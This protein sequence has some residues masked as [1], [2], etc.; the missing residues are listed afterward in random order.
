MANE[1]I[2]SKALKQKGWEHKLTQYSKSFEYVEHIKTKK[3]AKISVIIVAW[4]YIDDTILENLKLL[5]AQIANESE[6]IFVNNGSNDSHF[7]TCKEFV[8]IYV[9][10]N[11]N[12]GLCVSRNIGCL[13][14]NAPIL[15]FIDDDCIPDDN[16]LTSH[17]SLHQKYDII[18]VRGKVIPKTQGSPKPLHYDLGNQPL[19]RFNDCEGNSSYNAKVFFELQG[20]D[21][22]LFLGGE[23]SDFSIR[24]FTQYPEYRFQIYA[25]QPL[26]YHDYVKDPHRAARKKELNNIA[27]ERLRSKYPKLDEYK[28]SF[29]EHKNDEILE[30]QPVN[31]DSTTPLISVCMPTYNCGKYI[32]EAIDSVLKQSFTSYEIVILDDG[33]TDNTQAVI[34][35]IQQTAPVSIR[36]YKQ[37]NVGIPKTRNRLIE[38]AKA[39]YILWF[40]SDDLLYS[41]IMQIHAQFIARYPDVGVFYG[42]VTFFGKRQ[43]EWIV[44]DYYKRSDVL[45]SQIID[46]GS[47]LVNCGSVIKKSVYSEHGGYD[48]SY[49]RAQD[50][51]FWARIAGD[52]EVKYIGTHSIYYRFHGNNISVITTDNKTHRSYEAQNITYLLNKYPLQQLFPQLDWTRDKS[53][54]VLAYLEIAKNYASRYAE[55]KALSYYQKAFAQMGIPEDNLTF[56]QIINYLNRIFENSSIAGNHTIIINE[57]LQHKDSILNN[58]LPPSTHKDLKVALGTLNKALKDK[59]WEHK[60]GL[61]SKYFEYAERLDIKQEPKISIIVIAWK[62]NDMIFRN[63]QLLRHQKQGETELIFLNNGCSDPQ[64]DA[65]KEYVDTYI[66]LNTNTGSPIARNIAT[67]FAHAPILCFVDDDC[68]PD[69]NLIAAHT[70]IHQTY[71]ILVLRGRVLPITPGSEKPYHYELDNRMMPIFCD[72]EGNSSFR[73]STFYEVNGWNDELFI[74]NEGLDLCYR[75]FQ[76]YPEYRYQIFHPDPLIYHDYTKDETKTEERRKLIEKNRQTLRTKYPDI[77]NFIQN[78]ND[79]KDDEIIKLN[80]ISNKGISELPTGTT[81]DSNILL[82]KTLRDKGWDY[83]YQLYS[84]HFGII[85]HPQPL[86]TPKISIIFVVWK[87]N[88][89]IENNLS[90]L[91]QQL[92]NET[93]IILVNNGSND[94]K[95]ET[96]KQYANIYIKLNNNTGAYLSRNIGGLFANAPILFFIEDDCIPDQSLIASHVEL[97][98][99]YDIISARGKVIPI[100]EG[101]ENPYH[102]DL[103]PQARCAIGNFEGNVTYNA[104]VFYSLGGWDDEI[105]FGY[106][107]LEFSLRIWDKYPE[108]RYQIYS[109]QPL[110]YHDFVKETQRATDKHKQQRSS[111]IRLRKKYPY[112]DE[113]K[114]QF[115]LHQHDPLVEKCPTT[116]QATIPQIPVLLKALREKGWSHKYDLYSRCFQ[117]IEYILPINAPKISLVIVLWKYEDIIENNLKSIRTQMPDQTEIVLVNNGSNDQRLLPLKQYANTFVNLNTNTGSYL[118]RNIG[119]L[120]ANAPILFFYEDDCIPSENLVAEHIALHTRYDIIAARGKVIP[121]TEGSQEPQHYNLGPNLVCALGNCEG[122]ITF[123]AQ[124]FYDLSG[125]DDDIFFG[126]G[127]LELSYRILLK[128][129]EYRY[130]IYAPK[131]IIHHD[132]VKD[133]QRNTRKFEMQEDSLKRL[134][135]KYPNIEKLYDGFAKHRNDTIVECEITANRGNELNAIINNNDSSTATP[136]LFSICIPTYNNAKY[137]QA[138][139]ESVLAQP[140]QDYEIIILDDGSTDNTAEVIQNIQTSTPDKIRY[141]QQENQGIP[142][143]RNNLIDL[144]TSNWILWLDS[145][146][147][148]FGDV[149]KVYAEFMGKYKDA[150]VFYGSLVYFGLKQGELQAADYYQNSSSLIANSV[151]GQTKVPGPGS[152]VKKSVYKNYGRYNEEFQRAEDIE[153]VSRIAGSVPCKY[154]HTS[155]VYCRFHNGNASTIKTTAK[156]HYSYNA[157]IITYLLNKYS[158]QE[159]FRNYNWSQEQTTKTLVYLEIARHYARLYQSDESLSYYQKAFTEAGLSVNDLS[160]QK[161][162]DSLLVIF[163]KKNRAKDHVNA[164]NELLKNKDKIPEIVTTSSHRFK[165]TRTD[166]IIFTLLKKKKWTSRFDLYNQYFELAEQWDVKINPKISVVIVANNYSEL[167]ENNLLSLKTQLP[168]QTEIILLNNGCDDTCFCNLKEKV[169][170]YIK[171]TE[172]IS[173]YIAKNIAA[174]FTNARL[175]LFLD[176]DCIP[177]ENLVETHLSAHNQYDVIAVRGKIAPLTNNTQL[178]PHCD[179]GNKT[180]TAPCNMGNNIFIISAV[181]FYIGGWEDELLH[182]YGGEEMSYKLLQRYSNHHFQ[183]YHP[184]AIISVNAD[185]INAVPTQSETDLTYLKEKYP[186]FH[187]VTQSWS[188]HYEDEIQPR[189]DDSLPLVKVEPPK[190]NTSQQLPMLLKTLR[191]RGWEY[192]YPLYSKPFHSVEQ[193]NPIKDPTISVVMVVWKFDEIILENFKRLRPQRQEETEIIL[194]NNGSDDQRVID[195]QKYANIYVKLNTNTGAYLSRN[196]GSVFANAPTIL[197]LE[198]DCLPEDNLIT[199]FINIHNKYDVIVARGRVQ[200]IT[201]DSIIPAQYDFGFETI[202]IYGDFEGNVTYNA[203]IFYQLGGW[204]DE[205]FMGGGGIEIAYRIFE[206]YPEY[207]YQIYSP[208]P[209]VYHD[210]VKD[211]QRTATKKQLQE[212][213]HQRLSAK[214]PKLD[215]FRNNYRNHRYDQIFE[216][217]T[218]ILSSDKTKPPLVSICIPTFNRADFLKEAIQSAININFTDYEIVIVDDGSTDNTRDGVRAFQAQH[219]GLIRYFFKK[220]EG[221]PKTRNRLIDEARGEYILWLDSDDI[222]HPDILNQYFATD[223]QANGYDII[224]SDI[225]TFDNETKAV[226]GHYIAK[227]Y[228]ENEKYIL[229]NLL[230]HSGITFP[231][232]LMKRETVKSV[233]RF[234]KQFL[235]AQDYELWSRL[236]PVAHFKKVSKTLYSLR[237]HDT[238]ISS[239]ENIFRDTSYESLAIKRII[240]TYPLKVIFTSIDWNS[241][242]AITQAY[243][244]VAKA[245]FRFEDYY[246]CLQALKRCQ[247]RDYQPLH[248]L[249]LKALIGNSDFWQAK[250]EAEKLFNLTNNSIYYNLAQMA[251]RME[252]AFD[253]INSG[254]TLSAEQESLCGN[255]KGLLGFYPSL[256]Y[257]YTSV[258]HPSEDIRRKAYIKSVI[259][260]PTGDKRCRKAM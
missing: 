23:G 162:I 196:I 31:N 37:E 28:Q 138:T 95:L 134:K 150:S 103:G 128:Y 255:L 245:F 140:F 217:N 33:S 68:I 61:Y 158:L 22:G 256:F 190:I 181:F 230:L 188:E 198:D 243:F 30:R 25:P 56:P 161:V 36:Y 43:G 202:C 62:Y 125:W 146:D 253:A 212:K 65:F 189:K 165:S 45:I 187:T 11:T 49:K 102:Y 88:E 208:E 24:I 248:E 186:D 114:E 235:R 93:E 54:K 147:I 145:D 51:Q 48:E 156:E 155:S 252:I 133:T 218:P 50:S 91:R 201:K 75:I 89:L 258:Y 121:I 17:I 94:P 39:P 213:S 123:K 6:I 153:F 192:K 5:H 236:A 46:G 242:S 40:D 173:N 224:Y 105:F 157:K 175:L 240:S 21:D 1:N 179:L 127:G 214:Y 209:L 139:I 203:K 249:Y 227:D 167:L 135:A 90:I 85:E 226:N 122:N 207:R 3:E 183:I 247:F 18:T 55:S 83:K 241:E 14:A 233:G 15:C 73:A 215:D 82:L 182:T 53:S 250:A 174:L 254:Q 164:I 109:P 70:D 79:H 176:S 106:G 111:K 194:V 104:E 159:L 27:I 129:P 195:L 16:L 63:L 132:F 10:L 257:T 41:G 47:R 219:P 118:S 260:N 197:F 32:K 144:A 108:Y 237:I 76:K 60:Q 259:T 29:I 112:L 136:P 205:I 42:S 206:S 141:Y 59:G 117:S 223:P 86:S 229:E 239:G 19:C 126:Y 4:Q 52:V 124:T 193:V 149:L 168:T 110:I 97:H 251:D 220:N 96:F 71:D 238:N 221:R 58:G 74:Y 38:L 211:P 64:F 160:F 120:F 234:N 199:S 216:K 178:P 57:L 231:G 69:Q 80:P 67:L 191:Q 20:W 72:T 148:L 7:E 232:S 228:T 44:E 130:Q 26:I 101:S 84:Q 87:F 119:S 78:W 9:K 154:I 81:A 200:P 131:A 113:Y 34:Q 92:P 177:C 184:Q 204:D 169:D 210:Y 66:K 77:D 142:K 98:E 180:I 171:L 163:G 35:E 151:D 12:T 170:I 244:F 13:F 152:L 225:E 116:T 246:S 172:N 222:L 137:I 107:G 166:N 2:L 100:T 8:D 115:V 185:G 99:R 143:T